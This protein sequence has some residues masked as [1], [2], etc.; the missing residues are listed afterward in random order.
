[1]PENKVP[2]LGA[3]QLNA[4][5]NS[6]V[7]GI[8]TLDRNGR[9]ESANRAA[10]VMFQYTWDELQGQNIIILMP[11]PYRSQHD[12]Y[13]AHHLETGENRIIG[14]GREVQGCKR[15][16]TVFPIHLSVGRFEIGETVHFTGIVRDLTATKQTELALQRAHKMEA[17][18]QLTGGI[19]HDFNNLLTVVTGNLELMEMR[20]E[21]EYLLS[22]LSEAQEASELGARLTHR[23]LAFARRSPLEPE[24]VD[25]NTMVVGLTDLLHRTLGEPIELGSALST[26]LWP[27][28]ADR[29]QVESAIVN[30]AVNARDAMSGGGRLFIETQNVVVDETA[31][32][33]DAA[34]HAGSRDLDFAPGDYVRLS[35]IDTGDGIPA[36]TLERVFEP[37]FTTKEVGRGT[38]LGLSMVYGFAKQSRGNATIY[39]EV[40][41]GTTVNIYLP[42]HVPDRHAKTA[43]GEQAPLAR[44]AGETILVVEDDT[45]VR[46]LTVRRLSALG[47][48]VVEAENG[49]DAVKRIQDID[50]LSL[51]FTD[52][53]MPGGMTGY[54][55]VEVARRMRPGLK[56]LLTSGYAEDLLNADRLT[57]LQVRLL[58]KPYR[59][60]DLATA[61]RRAL[62]PTES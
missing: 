3:A 18:G 50:E 30:L 7:D 12:A 24:I 21:D 60:T 6:A 14:I 4:I 8:I 11:E 15:D 20:L 62:G 41:T 48:L 5:L 51:L 16:G 32:M 37:F 40:G 44:G 42:R 33:P 58:R 35:I 56:V 23:L 17:I 26:G 39:S 31:I 55:L 19:A 9:I 13:M 61:I 46:T 54:D 1:M 53:V 2:D 38:G 52:L 34:G 29:G 59:Q 36:E 10:R 28:L 43:T 47:Y 45:K 22:L 27:V 49:P 25:L 57:D